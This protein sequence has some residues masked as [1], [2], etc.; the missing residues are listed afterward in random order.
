MHMR[1]H[2]H[3]PGAGLGWD[4]RQGGNASVEN[5]KVSRNWLSQ[6][7]AEGKSKQKASHHQS[8]RADPRVTRVEEAPV[9][10][11]CRCSSVN[12]KGG[13]SLGQAAGV[14]SP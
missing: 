11:Y 6:E 2:Q 12:G 14:T 9:S 13:V 8:P 4:A 7:V 5:Y 10:R 3:S 1:H